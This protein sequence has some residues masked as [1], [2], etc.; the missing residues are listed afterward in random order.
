MDATGRPAVVIDNGTGLA[1]FLPFFLHLSLCVC[2][3]LS[4]CLSVWISAFNVSWIWLSI[5]PAL[6]TAGWSHAI[7]PLD[8]TYLPDC[9]LL[10]TLTRISHLRVARNEGTM[11]GLRWG[12]WWMAICLVIRIWMHSLAWNVALGDCSVCVIE[13]IVSPILQWWQFLFKS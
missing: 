9:H 2:V 4:V 13:G 5:G 6:G 12:L 10:H 7:P 11:D 1:P 8:G 3:C